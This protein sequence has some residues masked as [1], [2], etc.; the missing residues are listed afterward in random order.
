MI[1]GFWG[2]IFGFDFGS[3]NFFELLL[4]LGVGVVSE[5]LGV[6][7]WGEGEEWFLLSLV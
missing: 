5:G 2:G 3:R 7:G 6:D 4:G 1:I